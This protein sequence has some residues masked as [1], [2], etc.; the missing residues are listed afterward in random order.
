[1]TTY[2]NNK[3]CKWYCRFQINGERHNYLCKGA[4]TRKEAEKI[5]NA[6]KYKIQ[7]QQNGVIPRENKNIPLY[8]LM[9]LYSDYNEINNKDKVH[10]KSKIEDIKSYFGATTPIQKIKKSDIE[11]YR[12]YLREQK[13]LS[14]STINKYVYVLSKA[15]NLAIADNL[16]LSNPCKGIKKLKEDNEITRYLSIE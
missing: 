16:I 10:K 11:N 14:N 13:G 1:M 5:E 6:F 2:Q 3:N 4:T 15:Y 12:K 9:N 8:K 7:Q